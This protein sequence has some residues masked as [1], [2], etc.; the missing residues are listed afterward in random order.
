MV[1]KIKTN[2]YLFISITRRRLYLPLILLL[3]ISLNI[4]TG[5]INDNHKVTSEFELVYSMWC[6]F[7]MS[8]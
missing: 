7:I 2:G 1:L 4:T 8:F 3:S 6:I 5:K